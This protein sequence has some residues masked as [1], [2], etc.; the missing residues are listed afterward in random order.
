MAKGRFFHWSNP[1]F[2][3]GVALFLILFLIGFVRECRAAQ[4]EV[5][6]GIA[7]AY[8]WN[9]LKGDAFAGEVSALLDGGRW[10][11]SVGY[12]GEQLDV[13]NPF[14]YLSA[15]RVVHLFKARSLSPFMGLGLMARTHSKN[16]DE[17][18]PQWWN[19]SLSA[20]MEMGDHLRVEAR[21]ASNAGLETPNRG[22]N[23][24]LVGWRF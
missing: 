9:Y 1:A 16:V 22:V 4:F 17:L 24:F 12:I 14:T 8:S 11:L 19:F 15:Q 3:Y 7:S 21:H 6:G 10:D 13:V 23:W 20:G 5:S 18:L 2:R